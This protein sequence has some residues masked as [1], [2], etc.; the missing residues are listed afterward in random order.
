MSNL[1]TSAYYYSVNFINAGN[2]STTL[3]GILNS[4]VATFTVNNLTFTDT[5]PGA[6]KFL[7]VNAQ[8]GQVKSYAENVVV[9][10]AQLIS[11]LQINS[12]QCFK[13]DTKILTNKGYIP[14]QELKKGDLVKT[15]KHDFKQIYMICKREIYHPAIKERIKYHLYQCSQ[16]DYP[17][18]FEPLVITGCHSILVDNFISEEQ[19]QKVIEVNG[20]IYVTDNKYRL[21]ACAD[22]HASIYAIA[23]TYTIYHL[24]LE[25]DDYYMNYG[26]YANGLLVETCSKRYLSELSNMS[27]IE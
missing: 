19:K 5:Q 7:W 9:N 4:G 20:E 1:V 14:I 25:N 23:G 3:K 2:V 16:S 27:L 22:P 15:L 26:I 8:N 13:E 21:P 11:F 24:A 6:L 12:I 18:I 10:V 17:E